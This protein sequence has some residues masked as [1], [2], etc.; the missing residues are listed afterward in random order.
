MNVGERT[1]VTGSKK[2]L[3]LIKEGNFEEALSIAREQVEGGA[4]VI[5]VN[6]DEGMLDSEQ[7]MTTFLNLI[8]SEPDIC[9]VPIMI[10]SSKWTVI[11]A[12]LKCVQGKAI[13]NSISLKEGEEKFIEQALKIKQY[14]AAV[15]VMAFDEVGQAD[16]LQRRIDICKRAYDMLVNKVD[17]PAQ[18]IIFDPNIFPVA[19]GMEEHR[20]N[21]LD[22]FNAT[23]W[24]KENLPYAKVSGGVS[25]V[26]FS[27]RGNDHVRE[28]IHGAFLYHAVKNGMD[29]GIVNPSQLQ[30]YDDIDKTLLELVEDVLLNRRDDATE[31][32]VEHA[33]SLKGITKEKTEKDEAW[34]KGTVEERL[35]HALVKGIVEYID[36][37]TEEARLKLG[38]PLHVIEGPLMDGMNVVG[39]LF[40]SGKMFLP[41]VVKSAR[42]MKKAVAYLEPYLLKEKEDNAKAGIVGNGRTNAGKI[43]MAT[44]KGDVHDIGKNIVGVVLACNNYEIIDLGVMVSCDKILEEA[45]KHNVDV[46]GLSGLITPSLDEMVYVAKEMERLNF[47]TP[48]L[49]GGATTSKVHTAVKI[50][51]NYSGPVVHVNDASKSVPVASSLISEELRDAFMAEVNKDYERVREQNKNAQSQ[52]KFLSLAEA[53][54][55]KFPIDWS[56]QEIVKPSF[57]GNKVFN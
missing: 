27:F 31:R 3:R 5:D 24:I 30:V 15:I 35:S 28:A 9:R 37:D 52:N 55:N 57:T 29:M 6:M 13:V 56:K 17:F 22:F 46:I 39:D 43:L 21:A 42:V 33:E 51:Q 38:R 41:Q 47:K 32:L 12:G 25:N 49:I 44:V 16:T 14:G 26:S 2:F 10:D 45:K 50:A 20:L 54:Q 11:E 1:N 48:L 40:G 8:A 53:R 18:D 23:K 36:E 7:A 19:T 4:Q 34:R